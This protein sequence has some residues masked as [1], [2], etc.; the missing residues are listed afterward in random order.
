MHKY[1]SHICVCVNLTIAA[2]S[3]VKY[4]SHSL[5]NSGN[6][7]CLGNGGFASFKILLFVDFNAFLSF[8]FLGDWEGKDFLHWVAV[9]V[10]V[11]GVQTSVAVKSKTK[12]NISCYKKLND[13]TVQYCTVCIC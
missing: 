12:L 4:L 5:Q 7:S 2:N 1:V 6:V 9:L 8:S 13:A 10:L 3:G 11:V